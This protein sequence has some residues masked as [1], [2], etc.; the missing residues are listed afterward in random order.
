[1]TAFARLASTSSVLLR[2]SSL[3]I[4]CGNLVLLESCH[5]DTVMNLVASSAH[6]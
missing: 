4:E 6:V 1:M 5:V 2:W 3:V